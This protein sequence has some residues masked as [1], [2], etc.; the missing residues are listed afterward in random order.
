MEDFFGV[1]AEREGMEVGQ[2]ATRGCQG[3]SPSQRGQE[4]PVAWRGPEACCGVD[5]GFLRAPQAGV[6]RP[7]N[8]REVLESTELLP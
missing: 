5:K 2:R 8:Q 1:N 6:W 4:G 7:Q 3:Y